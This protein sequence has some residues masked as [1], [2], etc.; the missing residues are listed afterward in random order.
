MKGL[1]DYGRYED[2]SNW[3]GCPRARTSETPCAARDGQS[4]CD[5]GGRCVG[6]NAHPAE[7]LTKLVREVTKPEV[8]NATNN[9]AEKEGE[10]DLPG[11][12]V[13]SG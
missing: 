1:L 11:G 2:D 8:I 10:G 4:A 6:C 9:L 3:I 13:P 5:D 12:E 7:L